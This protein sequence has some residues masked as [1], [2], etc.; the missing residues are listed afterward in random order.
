M[1]GKLAEDHLGRDIGMS[2]FPQHSRRR[3]LKQGHGHELMTTTGTGETRK[4]SR[5]QV[6][7][8]EVSHRGSQNPEQ[9][10]C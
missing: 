4:L 6:R 10:N 9:G 2:E 1:P 3:Q 7:S 5:G 8:A